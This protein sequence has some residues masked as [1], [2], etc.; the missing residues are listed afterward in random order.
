MQLN[1]KIQINSLRWMAL[2]L[3]GIV[4]WCFGFISTIHHSLVSHLLC[5]SATLTATGVHPTEAHGRPD[6]NGT[7]DDAENQSKN[8]ENYVVL[9]VF[10]KIINGS[11]AEDDDY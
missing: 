1:K 4:S 2:I 8:C 7:L 10:E 6:T 5:W 3:Y 11:T 9:R